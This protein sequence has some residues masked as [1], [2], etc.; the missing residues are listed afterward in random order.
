MAA[1][2][3]DSCQDSLCRYKIA[4][5]LIADQNETRGHQRG[6]R[7]IRMTHIARSSSPV[8][9]R[10][11]NPCQRKQLPNLDSHVEAHDVRDQ[12]I[13]G[14]SE[15]LELG[16]QT[17]TVKKAKHQHRDPSDRLK[18]QNPAKSSNIFKAFIDD[19]QPDDRINDVG[20]Y[21]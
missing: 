7:D 20:I 21:M 6:I 3:S 15:L 4:G 1:L 12:S 13:P 10:D 8:A 5:H 11:Q 9:Q 2:R 14:E 16:C 18:S 17:E 19:R